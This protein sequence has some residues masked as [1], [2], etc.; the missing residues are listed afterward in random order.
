MQ[1]LWQICLLDIQFNICCVLLRLWSY[2]LLPVTEVW[3]VILPSMTL[4]QPSSWCPL[5]PTAPR[6]ARRARCRSPR[7]PLSTVKVNQTLNFWVIS[8]H[9][10]LWSATV[11]SWVEHLSVKLKHES[12]HRPLTRAPRLPAPSAT[13]SWSRPPSERSARTES[14]GSCSCFIFGNAK[15]L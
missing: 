1:N 12:H 4:C 5:L 8:L 3:S 14:A 2:L 7:Q 15:Q 9:V 13:P 10:C 11:W 6:S